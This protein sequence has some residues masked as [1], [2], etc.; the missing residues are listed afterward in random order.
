MQLLAGN[1]SMCKRLIKRWE[2]LINMISSNSDNLEGS[3]LSANSC[4]G[5]SSSVS[6][7]QSP[8]PKVKRHGS[9]VNTLSSK[10]SRVKS[11]I[12]DSFFKKGITINE[13]VRMFFDFNVRSIL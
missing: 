5:K 11:R 4:E 2:S 8:N 9:L 1:A 10:A 12:T 6:D 3:F 7:L 13:N